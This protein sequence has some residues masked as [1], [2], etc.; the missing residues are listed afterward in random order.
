M[1]W[2]IGAG[3]SAPSPVSTSL[4]WL[5]AVYSRLRIGSVAAFFIDV[6]HLGPPFY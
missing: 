3:T 2:I 4:S 5:S 6:F 1:L